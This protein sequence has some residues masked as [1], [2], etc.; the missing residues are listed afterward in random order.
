MFREAGTAYHSRS[1]GFI[2]VFGGV[3]I[4]HLFTFLCCVF[5]L[6]V[7]VLC[8]AY[9]MLPLS[10]DCPFSIAPSV[11]FNIYLDSKQIFNYQLYGR[12]NFVCGFVVSYDVTPLKGGYAV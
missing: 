8:L 7:F 10:L 5:A 9:P 12:A 4:A 11:F 1:H 2:L 6:R 3:C